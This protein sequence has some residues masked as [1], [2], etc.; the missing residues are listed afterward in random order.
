M[1]ERWTKNHD[2]RRGGGGGGAGEGRGEQHMKALM[3]DLG[4]RLACRHRSFVSKHCG[5]IS[6]VAQP[7]SYLLPSGQ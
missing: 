6:I 1:R 4:T 3:R 7:D 5:N 2:L